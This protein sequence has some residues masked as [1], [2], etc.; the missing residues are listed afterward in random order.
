[1]SLPILNNDILPLSNELKVRLCASLE[2]CAIP[3]DAKSIALNFRDTQYFQTGKGPSP[4]EVHLARDTSE[5]PW[6]I[7]VMAIFAYPSE[8]STQMEVKLYFNFKHGWFYQ[9]DI[10]HCDL[11]QPEV[12][13]LFKSW[14]KA[15]VKLLNNKGF[16][17]LTLTVLK[18]LL[19]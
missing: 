6:H 3:R 12:I 7:A 19:P 15:F 9:P 5:S 11:N 4:V 17:Q 10:D 2:L 13:D 14:D 8:K 16:N 1:M 18:T